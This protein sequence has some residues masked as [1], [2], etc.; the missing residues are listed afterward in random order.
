MNPT[1]SWGSSSGV[2]YFEYCYDTTN[3]NACSSWT[4]NGTATS[5]GLSGLSTSTIYYW[6]VRAVNS[7]GTTYANGS[8]TAFWSFTTGGPP[9]AFVKISPA[10]S[11]TNQLLNP[12]LSW[13][14]SIGVTSYDYCYDTTNDNSCSG[15]TNNGTATNV[16]LSGLST[17]TTYYWHVRAV[18]IFGTTYSNGSS[19][20]FWSFTTGIPPAA[21]NKSLPANGA[22][23]QPSNPTLSWGASSGVSYFEYC[24]DTTNDSACSGWTNNGTT[25]SVGLS[26]LSV[27]TI[28]YW[29]VRAV[30]SIGTTYS[31]GSST[32]FWSFTTGSP[33]GA[34][35]KSLPANGATDQPLNL[36]LSWGSS[37]GV[38]YFEYCYDTSN[39]SACS[40][41]T[42]NGT[43]THVGISGLSNSTTYYWHVRSVNSFGMTY[44]NDSITAFWS[45]TS[46]NFV[47]TYLPNVIK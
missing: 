31:N 1:L 27:S 2:S 25:T 47:F 17:G 37:S 23:N 42:S 46:G 15:W 6:H 10:N 39:D 29:H 20:A 21:F 38:S 26:G 33:P 9:G 12:T 3:D 7:F 18:N 28:Y 34:F 19:T 5:V 11:A 8:S 13:G 41:W 43:A 40:G 24:Y 35:S 14:A 32:A 4:N 45:F 22:T 30:N 16:G 44:A 36:T